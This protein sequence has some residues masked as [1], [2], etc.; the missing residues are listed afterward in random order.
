MDIAFGIRFGRRRNRSFSAF[1]LAILLAGAPDVFFGCHGGYAAE[2]S[3]NNRRER[4][5][6]GRK[7]EGRHVESATSPDDGCERCWKGQRKKEVV[8]SR[9]ADWLHRRCVELK[10][11]SALRSVNQIYIGFELETGILWTAT[12]NTLHINISLPHQLETTRHAV[13]P[14]NIAHCVNR[15]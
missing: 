3:V 7:T 6:D 2:F 8:R 4:R 11:S 14:R 5:K 1:K 9:H 10:K 12:R 15:Y 13:M